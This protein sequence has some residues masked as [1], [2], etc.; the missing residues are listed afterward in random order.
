M[1]KSRGYRARTRDKFSKPFRL[2]GSIKM[3]NYLEKMKLGEYVDIVVD[4]AI[5]R[6]MPHLFYHGRTGRIFNVNPRSVG[7]IIHKEIRNRKI[8]KKLHVRREHVRKST[9]RSDFL[10]RIKENDRLKQ[11]AKKNGQKISTKRVPAMPREA[12]TLALDAD[13]LAVHS[14]APHLEIF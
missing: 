2:H 14:L 8:E 5:H 9:C 6:G 7:V 3:S 4:G 10:Q 1:G 12:I 11:E 13:N